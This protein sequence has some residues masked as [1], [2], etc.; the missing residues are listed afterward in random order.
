MVWLLVPVT[1]IVGA[2]LALIGV[3]ALLPREHVVARRIWLRRPPE[4]VWARI[5][6]HAAEPG[7]R[8]RLDHVERL[9]DEDGRERWNEVSGRSALTFETVAVDAPRKLVRRV[10]DERLPFGGS[11]TIEVADDG[12]GGSTVAV[13]EHGAV[14]HPLFRV[15]S[16]FVIGH[17]RTIDGY[18][19][20]LAASFGEAAEPEPADAAG[21]PIG[22]P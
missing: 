7:W 5:R 9:P 22:Y 16:R 14:K 6:D 18:L 8:S 15:I 13:T 19:H 1:A 21:L 3:G 12:A 11:W 17:T 20:D 2:L 4:A 10:A